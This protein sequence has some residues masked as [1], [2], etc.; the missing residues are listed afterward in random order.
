VNLDNECPFWAQQYLCTSKS[1]CFV[2]KCTDDEIPKPWLQEKLNPVSVENKELF[3]NWESDNI[4]RIEWHVEEKENENGVYVNL[5]ENPEAY[6][7]Y[8]G[9]KIWQTIYNENCFQGNLDEMCTEERVFYR[10]ISGLHT[11]I[12]TQLSEYY[13]DFDKNTPAQPNVDMFFEKV[14]NYPDRMLNLYFAYSVILRAI[15]RAKDHISNY[16]YN[17]GDLQ[18]DVET[19]HLIDKLYQITTTKCDY[20]FNET[21]LFA[22]LTKEHIKIQFVSYFHN[23]SRIMDCVECE[24]CRVYGKLQTYGIGTAFKIL[25]AEKLEGVDKIHLQRNE[26]IALMITFAKFSH[27]LSTID[28]MFERRSQNSWG[29]LYMVLSII[30]SIVFMRGFIWVAFKMFESKMYKLRQDLKTLEQHNIDDN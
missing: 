10:M 25:F 17:T 3:E 7:G 16:K 14:G 15:N 2:C 22:D 5:N 1:K 11:S 29:Q 21:E 27:S 18:S 12:S 30:G 8:Q 6:T 9:Q 28:K 4:T 20:P 24:K 13:I 23:I 26:L 19:K